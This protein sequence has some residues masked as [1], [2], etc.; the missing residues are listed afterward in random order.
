MR[1]STGRQ[2]AGARWKQSIGES[3]LG[4]ELPLLAVVVEPRP[5]ADVGAVGGTA[6]GNVEDLAA[7]AVD[8][9]HPGRGGRDELPLLAVV[10]EPRPLADIGAVAGA[11]TIPLTGPIAPAVGAAVGAVVGAYVGSLAGALGGS[12]AR[13]GGEGHGPRPVR[14]GGPAVSV[15]VSTVELEEAMSILSSAGALEIE[16]SEGEVVRGRLLG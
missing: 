13:E 9:A 7:V 16:R 14:Q 12:S 5:L 1:R 15:A 10:V 4:L 6:V 11:A 3:L 8:D 2:S